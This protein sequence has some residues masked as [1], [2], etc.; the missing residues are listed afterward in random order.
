[1]LLRK[2]KRFVNKNIL[3]KGVELTPRGE[4]FKNYCTRIAEEDNDSVISAYEDFLEHI[5]YQV[6]DTFGIVLNRK[7]TAEFILEAYK[8]IL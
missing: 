2:I 1:M 8:E 5:R 6:A 7:E 3:Y 4:C